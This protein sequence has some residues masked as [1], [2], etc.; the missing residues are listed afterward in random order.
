M[1]RGKTRLIIKNN[2][3]HTF[4]L[5]DADNHYYALIVE[6]RCYSLRLNY[7]ESFEK[8]Y[9]LVYHVVDE[10]IAIPR[11]PIKFWLTV[12]GEIS[13]RFENDEHIDLFV[14]YGGGFTPLDETRQLCISEGRRFRRPPSPHCHCHC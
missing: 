8:E 1:N 6:G 12:S 13:Q 2:S 10:T 14:V 4:Q 5:F 11:K 9:K 7:S 3:A